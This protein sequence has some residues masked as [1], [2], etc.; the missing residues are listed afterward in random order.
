MYT[1]LKPLFAR[2]FYLNSFKNFATG[3][4]SQ[5]FFIGYD[6]NASFEN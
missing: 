3:A 2:V 5:G 1:F 4:C 6:L